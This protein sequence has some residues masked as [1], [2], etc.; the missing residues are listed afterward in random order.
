MA[1]SVGNK[2]QACISPPLTCQIKKDQALKLKL[3][4]DPFYLILYYENMTW[5]YVFTLM[6][7]SCGLAIGII[8]YQVISFEY[9]V[10]FKLENFYV[11]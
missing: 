8:S 7:S 3:F 1:S 11:Q 10:V 2:V 6:L 4:V 9:I 5:S